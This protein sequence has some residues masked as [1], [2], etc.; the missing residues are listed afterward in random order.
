MAQDAPKHGWIFDERDEFQPVATA[1]ARQDAINDL[2]IPAM[3][4]SA[5]S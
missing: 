1:R 2:S 3:R 4:F 5:N